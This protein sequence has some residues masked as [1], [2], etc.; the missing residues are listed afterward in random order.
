MATG[1]S[2]P[3]LQQL[4]KDDAV[5]QLRQQKGLMATLGSEDGVQGMILLLPSVTPFAITRH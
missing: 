2:S 1:G 5:S 3:A 4:I